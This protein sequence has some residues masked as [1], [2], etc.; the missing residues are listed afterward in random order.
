MC[1][2]QQPA[3]QANAVAPA[4]PPA[5]APPEVAAIGDARKS[6]E[7]ATFGKPVTDVPTRIDRTIDPKGGSGVNTPSGSGINL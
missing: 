4:P 3:Q 6:E 2:P 5:E 7:Q 1:F